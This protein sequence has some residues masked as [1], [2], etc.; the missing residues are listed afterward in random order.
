MAASSA[1]E[2]TLVPFSLAHVMQLVSAGVDSK[3]SLSLGSYLSMSTKLEGRD[4]LTKIMQ[5]GARFFVWYF[6]R[7]D[8]KSPLAARAFKLYKTTQLSRKAFRMLKVLEEVLKLQQACNATRKPATQRLLHAL[9]A[10]AMGCFWSFDNLNYLTT[11]QTVAFGND[12]ALR[13]FSRSWFVGSA[14]MLVLGAQ[15][16]AEADRR[17]SE[18]EAELGRL[19]LLP[20]AGD[21]N[22]ATGS[23]DSA[24][25]SADASAA[26]FCCSGGGSG[27]S[28]S[29]SSGGSG[30]GGDG[31]A[32]MTAR[33]TAAAADPAATGSP[34]RAAFVARDL[35]LAR[36][37]EFKAGLAV[38]K[39]SLD[40]LCAANMP[41]M[42][43]PLRLAGKK[44]N[45]GVVGAAGVL[46]AM[47][48]LYGC[49]PD[50][51]PPAAAAVANAPTEAAAAAG[52]R[53]T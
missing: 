10:I 20:T 4:K 32:P 30:S 53:S 25:G 45:D 43:L 16:V 21:G 36:A 44:L 19:R 48:V 23:D 46:S 49:W 26:R 18:L 15:S 34:Q 38:L 39:S 8:P 7:H 50:A 22:G 11:T 52:K 9:R 3:A 13:G 29:G 47:T 14:I 28:S 37:E 6:S 31:E 2:D 35:A 27:G 17:R 5:Y 51:S 41:G 40:M 33:S 12:R 1:A 24:S 42:D